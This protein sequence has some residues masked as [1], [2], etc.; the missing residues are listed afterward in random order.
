MPASD[1]FP[2]EQ[3]MS[4]EIMKENISEHPVLKLPLANKPFM[5]DTDSSAYQLI[6]TLLQQQED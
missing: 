6:V 2:E 3:L 5:L 1:E 4:F